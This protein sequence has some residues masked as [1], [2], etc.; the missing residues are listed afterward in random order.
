MPD[1]LAPARFQ[2]FDDVLR[3]LPGL[4]DAELDVLD[5]LQ[6]PGV[7]AP[8]LREE[9]DKAGQHAKRPLLRIRN[10][11]HG[12][13][14]R[15]FPRLA[16]TAGPLPAAPLEPLRGEY[17]LRVALRIQLVS[18]VLVGMYEAHTIPHRI[19]GSVLEPVFS[20]SSLRTVMSGIPD[21]VSLGN[22]HITAPLTA[23]SARLVE[24]LI[25]AIPFRLELTRPAVGP[26]PRPARVVT[27][28]SGTLRLMV[29]LGVALAKDQDGVEGVVVQL[30]FIDPILVPAAARL[31]IDADSP[32]QAI[33]PGA[34]DDFILDRDPALRFGFSQAFGGGVLLGSPL[35]SIPGLDGAALRL[36]RGDV[37]VARDTVNVGLLL[38]VGTD[39][40]SPE[41]G[42]P[43]TLTATLAPSGPNLSATAHAALADKVARAAFI[44]GRL[45]ALADDAS[46]PPISVRIR[47]ASGTIDAEAIKVRIPMKITGF[48][49]T[50]LTLTYAIDL[51][52]TV[53]NGRIVVDIHDEWQGFDGWD[54]INCFLSGIASL[55]IGLVVPLLGGAWWVVDWALSGFPE[56]GED[57]APFI[58]SG[59]V[60]TARPISGTEQRA[61]V[62]VTSVGLEVDRMRSDGI[63]ALVRDFLNAYVYA[64][65]HDRS[66]DV[67]NPTRTPIAR[68]IVSLNDQ[69]RP[70]P[71]DEL[72]TVPVVETADAIVT[73]EVLQLFRGTTDSSLAA[74]TTNGDGRVRFVLSARDMLTRW[75]TARMRKTFVN[76]ATGATFSLPPFVGPI[77]ETAPD[78]YF[79]VQRENG[80]TVDTRFTP[81]VDVRPGQRVGTADQPLRFDFG[82]PAVAQ[83]PK[84]AA[85][86]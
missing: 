3:A 82:G 11:A 36:Q 24:H 42:D 4:L 65:F 77:N 37:R 25:I 47:G 80:T 22:F 69:D 15:R 45:Q 18:D 59:L 39:A 74:S 38:G 19:P 70:P 28:L 48:C 23:E 13:P 16:R 57:P 2:T 29:A 32:I 20:P 54:A 49:A 21:G 51:V 66:S 84:L 86:H 68:A 60:E 52:P 34:V 83:T 67:V 30:P 27:H 73:T 79:V 17:D 56:I 50:E 62:E 63:A 72:P 8:E 53:V 41:A 9:L 44:S 55:G 58:V 26:F 12:L 43:T 7:L 46:P 33:L 76:R 14:G 71:G 35:I 6:R 40:P 10:S 81:V 1:G 75:G 61:R 31:E 5:Y 78:L 64:E 85:G